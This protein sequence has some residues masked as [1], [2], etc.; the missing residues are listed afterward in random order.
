MDGLAA[1]PAVDAP[2]EASDSTPP[3]GRPLPRRV[4]ALVAV[5]AVLVAVG[6]VGLVVLR[7]DQPAISARDVNRIAQQ[8][9]DKAL[10]NQA[11]APADAT[12]AYQAILPSLVLISAGDATGAGVVV[13][14]DGTVLTALHVVERST[15]IRV[16]FADGTTALGTVT[17]KR[18]D[19]DIAV[20]AVNYLPDVVVPAVLGGGAQVGDPVFAVGHPLGL[21]DTLT[22]GVVSALGRTVRVTRDRSLKNLIQFDAAVNPGNS[23]GPLLNRSGQVVG[24][25]TGLANPADQAFFVGIGFA[26]PIATAGGA[27]GGPPQ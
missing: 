25:V 19:D 4:K 3:R 26:V 16:V 10:D 9:V 11:Q 12:R 27:A 17:K 20:V 23:G 22:S 15:G 24:I 14:A 5:V 8:R 13:N 7:P 18:P 6:V 1:P 2:G 21:A